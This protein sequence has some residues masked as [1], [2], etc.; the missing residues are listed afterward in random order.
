MNIKPD[1]LVIDPPYPRNRSELLRRSDFRFAPRASA[2]K[3]MSSKQV[4]P[5]IL[6]MVGR[7][8]LAYRRA[9]TAGEKR[10]VAKRSIGWGGHIERIDAIGHDAPRLEDYIYNCSLREVDE[11]LGLGEPVDRIYLDVINDD[12][13]PVGRVHLA[14]VEAWIY[15]EP[16]VAVVLESADVDTA[17]TLFWVDLDDLRSTDGFESWSSLAIGMLE[18]EFDRR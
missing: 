1:V 11:E 16:S 9:G 7:S 13:D 12:T 8:V 10:L 6:V 18:K 5:Y 17:D 15:D 4:I 3:D 14:Y 2:E